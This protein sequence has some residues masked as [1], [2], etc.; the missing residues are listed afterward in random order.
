M[1]ML[2]IA[3]RNRRG[4]VASASETRRSNA[5]RVIAG[6]G[7]VCAAGGGRPR[8]RLAR[9]FGRGAEAA[10]DDLPDPRG[11]LASTRWWLHSS[12]RRKWSMTVERLVQRDTEAEFIGQW[13][14][15]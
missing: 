12:S 10:Y 14:D 5:W 8:A 2:D 3:S 7:L 1:A 15:T 4:I 6:A 9:P 13:I 11:Y